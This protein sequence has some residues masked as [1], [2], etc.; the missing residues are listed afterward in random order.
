MK[1]FCL[2]DNFLSVIFLFVAT[3]CPPCSLGTYPELDEALSVN[4]NCYI[5]SRD[6]SICSVC[7][8]WGS[9]CQL[10]GFLLWCIFITW[11]LNKYC[12][13]EVVNK[14]KVLL[15]IKTK[16]LMQSSLNV[17]T[18][19]KKK[20]K[21]KFFKCQDKKKKKKKIM[22]SSINIK[23]KKKKIPAMKGQL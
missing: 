15:N 10:Q 11:L 20:K 3:F 18:K 13:F 21:L 1:T 8:W 4:G 6:Q 12:N 23:K 5:Y 9:L 17:K 2:W 16:K 19:K 7:G 22:E 14:W